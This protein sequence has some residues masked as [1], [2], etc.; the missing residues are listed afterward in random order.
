VFHP[1]GNGFCQVEGEIEDKIKVENKIKIKIKVENEVK[2]KVENENK[3]DELNI[4]PKPAFPSPITQSP[5]HQIASSPSQT[6]SSP[7]L[8]LQHCSLPLFLDF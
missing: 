7:I 8:T 5:D 6:A 1:L 4:I 3:V 2:A